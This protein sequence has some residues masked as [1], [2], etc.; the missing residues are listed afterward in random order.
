MSH[1][2]REVQQADCCIVGA[3]PAGAVLGLLLARRGV[4][5][6]LLEAHGD[7]EREFRGDTIHPSVMEIMEELGLADR[8]LEL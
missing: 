8:L 4:S 6:L 2:I 3:G 5:V 1:D 7:F